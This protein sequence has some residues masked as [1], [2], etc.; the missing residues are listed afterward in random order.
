ME[1]IKAEAVQPGDVLS[2]EY[3]AGFWTREQVA[4]VSVGRG[5]ARNV[6]IQFASGNLAIFTRGEIVKIVAR[7]E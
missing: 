3:I 4:T 1:T 6:Y 7:A 2:V 5:E